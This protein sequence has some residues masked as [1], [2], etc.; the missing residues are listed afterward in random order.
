[1]DEME[2]VKSQLRGLL[3]GEGRLTK[4]PAKRKKLAYAVH[5]IATKLEPDVRYT[6]RELNDLLNKWN[7]IGDPATLRREL[8]D[9]H[10]VDRE[11]DGSAYWMEDIQPTLAELENRLK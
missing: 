5:Y 3:D 10:Y 1:M 9:L 2:F 8:Y 11:P 4:I 6:E 7:T